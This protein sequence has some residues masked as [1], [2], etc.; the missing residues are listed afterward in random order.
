MDVRVVLK[1]VLKKTSTKSIKP[2][3]K[4]RTIKR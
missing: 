4:F 1:P 3:D 2:L